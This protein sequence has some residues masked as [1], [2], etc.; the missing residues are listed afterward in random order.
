MA[1]SRLAALDIDRLPIPADVLNHPAKPQWLSCHSVP[2][3]LG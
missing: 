1:Q 2:C 3:T